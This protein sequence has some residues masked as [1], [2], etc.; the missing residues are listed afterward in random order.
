MA[1]KKRT[2][3]MTI[4]FLVKPIGTTCHDDIAIVPMDQKLAHPLTL[5][6]AHVN[7]SGT[8]ESII[9]YPFRG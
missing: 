7:R 9:W 8:G 5:E 3:M 2:L 6:V 1:T 4:D